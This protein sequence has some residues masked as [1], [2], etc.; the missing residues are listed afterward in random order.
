MEHPPEGA[1]RGAGS[2][3]SCGLPLPSATARFC[4]ECGAPVAQFPVE[5]EKRKTVTLLFT[6]VTGST[7]LGE[8]LDPEAYRAV[9]G[10]YFAVASAAVERHGGN[11]EKFVGDAVLAV[12]GV[13]EVREDDALRAV[14]AA[15][16][17]AAGVESLSQDLVREL[18]VG[19]T[20][21]T[22]VNTGPVVTGADR[23]GGSFATGDA[24]NTAARLEQAAG[25]GEVLLGETTFALVRD[26][27]TVEE[28]EPVLAKGKA[29]PVRAYRLI[30]V[31]DHAAGRARRLDAVLIGRAQEARTLDDLLA[32]TLT[33]GRGH[34]VS[35]LG[36]PGIG[37][38]RLVSDFLDRVGE[39]ARVLRGRCVSYGQGI[40]YWPFVQVLRDAAALRG[41]ESPEVV[42]HALSDLLV[43]AHDRAEVVDL[44]LPLLGAGGQ[45]GDADQTAWAA[46]RLLEQLALSSPVVVE[47]DDLHWAE[48][49]LLELLQ[50][51]TEETRDLPLLLVCQARPELLDAHPTW[52]Q[53]SVNAVSLG[54]EPFA[55]T[56]TASA[57]EAILGP[58]LPESVADAVARWSGGNPL[59]V[60]EMAA[61]LVATGQLVPA[62]DG[63]G[64]RLAGDLD[65]L[66]VPDTVSALLA[67]RLERLPQAELDLLESVSVVGLEFSTEQARHLASATDPS[68]LLTSLSRREVVRRNR[69]A[70]AG[71]IWSFRHG[72][73][74]EAAYDALPKTDR[75]RLHSALADHLADPDGQTASAGREHEAFIAYHRT[76]AAGYSAELAPAD[77][78]TR[79][80]ADAAADATYD[81]VERVLELGDFAAAIAL[82]REVLTLPLSPSRRRHLHVQVILEGAG[83]RPAEEHRAA[84]DDLETTLDDPAEPAT[85]L[86]RD[87][88]AM[89]RLG[90]L[91][92]TGE[93][94]SDAL[95][96]QLEVQAEEVRVVATR[97][98]HS[99]A[100]TA[101]LYHLSGVNA[102]RGTWASVL[103]LN[104][105]V[106]EVGSLS[107]RR[108]ALRGRTNIYLI[109]PFP[110]QALVDHARATRTPSLPPLHL[111][112]LDLAE[113]A[114]LA[115]SGR[116]D[117]TR[118]RELEEV[119]RELGPA[120]SDHGHQMLGAIHM[121]TGDLA[122]AADN[123]R[124]IADANVKFGLYTYASTYLPWHALI[125]VDAGEPITDHADRIALAAEHTAPN[126]VM[127]V[128]FVS[129]A[130][131]LLA[132]EAGDRDEAARLAEHA[133][134]VMDRGD[135]IW[136]QADTR[137]WL[138]PVVG[139][140]RGRQLLIEARDLYTA[141]GLLFWQRH[142]EQLLA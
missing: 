103:D 117:P 50:R 90:H 92:D 112:A 107:R 93:D 57:L 40:T 132:A 54:L 134:A 56:H 37:K 113:Q 68:A 62:E 9:M 118:V 22:G 140:E 138:T 74:R 46:S 6:D 1:A 21:R 33:T 125:A 81:A 39:Q 49:T 133:I 102:F 53:G 129:A 64:W 142:V 35:V 88:I 80:L 43:A 32:R 86:E 45:P 72:L 29:E 19:L 70:T 4:S 16:E 13:P 82:Q 60:E 79:T 7:A 18:G 126:D 99:Y 97:T 10:R 67:A 123:F 121:W 95:L 28:V 48:P 44:L 75:I 141:K 116:H 98:K 23:A 26:A 85:S 94:A 105:E 20:I 101:A 42:R 38:T 8:K 12:F 83:A 100:L 52:G 109:G 17:V 120:S 135:Q 59:F 41:G 58:G 119:A 31:D 76:R 139:V 34:L 73:I 65:A 128:A 131:A 61:H 77:P 78:R 84:L 30:A 104:R 106:A 136:N 24:V 69:S 111:F 71:E 87:L 122:A 47:V 51:V 2:C 63:P 14:R 36:A 108:A 66:R 5:R 15:A 137:R 3:G 89:C 91:L 27:V 124:L 130:Q 55:E 115:A 110:A 25:P 114:G 11:V 96:E 127:S